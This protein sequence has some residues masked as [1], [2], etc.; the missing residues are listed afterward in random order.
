[1][2]YDWER[3]VEYLMNHLTSNRTPKLFAEN[4]HFASGLCG[5]H[6]HMSQQED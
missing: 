1:M 3:K 2:S 4:L 5:M 6:V